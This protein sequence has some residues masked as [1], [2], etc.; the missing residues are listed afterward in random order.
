MSNRKDDEYL[1][2]KSWI[3]EFLILKNLIQS[4]RQLGTIISD[5][6]S[7]NLS[8]RLTTLDKYLNIM[9]LAPMQ[10]EISNSELGR[11]QV[12]LVNLSRQHESLKLQGKIISTAPS[13][14]STSSS[15]AVYNSP[16]HPPFNPVNSITDKGLVNRQTLV[17][18]A[19]DKMLAEISQGVDRIHAHAITIGEEAV[20]HNKLIDN[21]NIQVDV[22]SATLN[23]ETKHVNK[24]RESS[25]MCS[26]Y[27]CVV[28]E[29]II[30]V[31]LLIVL[32]SK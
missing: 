22:A 13:S 2:E 20:V 17:I 12:I 31:I 6:D 10:Y 16:I 32:F 3:S 15:A 30:V 11:R 5:D 7:K 18:K 25:N 8:N 24:V 4:K 28:V 23:E 1:T 27:I 14:S 9:T 26:M 19:Q 21:L 29:I